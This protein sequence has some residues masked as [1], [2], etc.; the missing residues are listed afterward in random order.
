MK[1]VILISSLLLF[2]YGCGPSPVAKRNAVNIK[3]IK[4]GMR[5]ELVKKIMGEPEQIR[6]LPFN[7]KEYEFQYISPSLYSDDFRIYF[8]RNDSIVLRVVDGL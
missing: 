8:S 1:I 2:C 3:N 4:P 5:I 6:I 7:D